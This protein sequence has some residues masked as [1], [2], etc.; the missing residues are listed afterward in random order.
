MNFE[1]LRR[2]VV[3]LFGKSDT[4]VPP[5]NDAPS[6]V[7]ELLAHLRRSGLIPEGAD[8]TVRIVPLGRRPPVDEATEG[9]TWQKW[10]AEVRAAGTAPGWAFCRFANR[11]GDEDVGFVFGF[12]RG[13]FGIW[14]KPFGVCSVDGDG[15]HARSDE[16][17]T[18]ITHLR[19]GMGI[20]IFVER[21]V[22]FT[23]A[24]LADRVCPA[25]A[26]DRPAD[27][28]V[29]REAALRT[30]EAWGGVG[31][32]VSNN[33]H[34]HDDEGNIFGVMGRSEESIMHGKPE[35]LS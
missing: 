18:C 32:C 3:R 26:S 1:A 15:N 16:I 25:W 34:A 30:H 28:T 23:A 10:D 27:L 31:I 29:W 12:A 8:A 4:S 22:A 19:T 20:G 2:S 14:Q 24:E 35:K 7:D 5:K 33:S 13:S 6:A 17:L 21:E 9:W 11:L